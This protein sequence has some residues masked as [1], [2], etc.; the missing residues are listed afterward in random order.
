MDPVKP[1]YSGACISGLVSGVLSG[2]EWVP[3]VVRD[4]RCVVLFVVD[5]LGQSMLESHS[6]A[7]P[8]MSAM[9]N[10][11]ITSVVP[12]TT[13][14]ALTSIT[15]GLPPSEHGIVGYRMKVNESVLNVLRWSFGNDGQ[16]PEPD[17]VQPRESFA[18][19]SPAAVI[20]KSFIKTP[21]TKAHL[22][23]AQV[24]GYSATSQLVEHVRRLAE[25]ERFVYAYYD[26]LDQTCH[27]RGLLD[28]YLPRELAYIDR[29]VDE[30]VS[31]VSQDVVVVVSSDH[32]HV[33]LTDKVSLEA[34]APYVRIYA[35]DG[36]FRDLHARRDASIELEAACRS[37]YA[38]LAWVF[39]REQLLDEGWMGRTAGQAARQR[40]GD[41]ILAA[42]VPVMFRDPSMTAEASMQSGHGSLTPDEMWVPLA[43]TRGRG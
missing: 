17:R 11:P 6:S 39:T 40:L 8:V 15:T 38:D 30:M 37:E 33:H 13:A 14:A 41:V 20:R 25:T 19:R 32:G 36:R 7:M 2:A 18:G 9:E 31:C 26:G 4:A 12:S 10:R 23:G 5:G 3:A 35:G 21:F 29:M 24:W 22:R 34:V 1:D 28:G 27:E 43:A 42:K 16:L